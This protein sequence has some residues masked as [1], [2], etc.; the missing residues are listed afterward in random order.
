M[1]DRYANFANSGLGRTVV[2]RLG[3]P[4]P[5]RLRRFKAGD[6]LVSGPVLLGA[7]PGG[8]LAEPV[9][10]LLEATGVEIKDQTGEGVRVSALVFD[11]TGIGDSDGLRALYDFFHPYAR[12]L[13]AS[14]RVIV[15]GSPPET[16]ASPSEA[17]AQRSL[18]GLT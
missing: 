16:T 15:L 11:A 5:P 14:G 13:Q 4:D 10:K 18:E 17:I 12:A 1:A 7:A 9:R 2:K 3:L 6:P 8:R